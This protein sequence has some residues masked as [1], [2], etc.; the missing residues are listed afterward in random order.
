MKP[1]SYSGGCSILEDG[2][3]IKVPADGEECGP[4]S[5]TKDSYLNHVKGSVALASSDSLR[6][7]DDSGDASDNDNGFESGF[8]DCFEDDSQLEAQCGGQERTESAVAAA[9]DS[10]AFKEHLSSISQDID[11]RRCTHHDGFAARCNG[12]PVCGALPVGNTRDDSRNTSSLTAHE[13][14]VFNTSNYLTSSVTIDTVIC[15]QQAVSLE[16][17]ETDI[18]DNHK[19]TCKFQF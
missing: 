9:C 1:T 16:N 5:C 6:D 14:S 10:D 3:D 7:E 15:G 19:N 11:Q 13:N 8:D 18:K 2:C 12:I 17:A 4:H